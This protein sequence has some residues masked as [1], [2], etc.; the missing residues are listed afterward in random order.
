MKRGFINFWGGF[1]SEGDSFEN[2]QTEVLM[3]QEKIDPASLQEF[4]KQIWDKAQE[5]EGLGYLH[6]MRKVSAR[7]GLTSIDFEVETPYDECSARVEVM[8]RYVGVQMDQLQP[9]PCETLFHKGVTINVEVDP[10]CLSKANN[11]RDVW[12]D[13][14]TRAELKSA[15]GTL[16]LL[17]KR[18][19]ELRDRDIGWRI[20]HAIISAW[21][22]GMGDATLR[23][24][25]LKAFE[26]ATADGLPTA[27]GT[28]L[29]V[30]EELQKHEPKG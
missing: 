29:R 30:K 4:K 24:H 9:L 17:G 15:S 20:D 1:L 8:L 11:V 3:R 21:C 14:W 6:V 27:E 18:S 12:N 26:P 5:V 16:E 28:L 25:A 2:V 10:R 13:L 23:S 19:K 7:Y 22:S